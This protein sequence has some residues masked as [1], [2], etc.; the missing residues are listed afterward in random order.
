M[1]TLCHFDL[2]RGSAV[3]NVGG[4]WN[5]RENTYIPIGYCTSRMLQAGFVT[6]TLG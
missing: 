5:T 3:V 1:V 6:A 4:K 2:S